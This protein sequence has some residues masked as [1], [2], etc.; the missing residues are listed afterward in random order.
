M[1]KVDLDPATEDYLYPKTA[2]EA[3]HKWDA[4]GPVFTIELGGLGPGYEQAIH[5][6]VFELIRDY[7]D[8]PLANFA[9][10]DRDAWSRWGEPAVDRLNETCGFS[11]AQVGAA[12][13]YAY[14]V[15]KHG[16]RHMVMQAPD[17]RLI[18]VSRSFPHPPDAK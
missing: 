9:P 11:G 13:N 16:W 2:A 12:K 18:Q 6:L 5:V 17:D 15:L 3:L 8:S 14:Q 4:G 7:K 1:K 10:E